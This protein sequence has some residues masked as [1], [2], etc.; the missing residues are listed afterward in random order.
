M[1][2]LVS[3]LVIILEI[4]KEK[5][6]DYLRLS[7]KVGTKVVKQFLQLTLQKVFT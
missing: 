7:C 3:Q 1:T 5:D 6:R 2:V 4:W